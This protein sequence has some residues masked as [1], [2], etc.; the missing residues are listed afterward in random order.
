L[1]NHAAI[2]PVSPL[3]VTED[4]PPSRGASS[5]KVARNGAFYFLSLGVPALTALFLV[6]VTVRSLGP[7]R[8][9]L[10]AL[11]WA[12][13]EGSG[14]F[15]FGLGRATVRF[16]ADA[17]HK[18]R[19]RLNEIVLASAFSQTAA[20]IVA[21]LLLFFFAPLLVSR[22]FTISPQA[23]PE[24]TAMFRVLALHLPVLL[25]AAALR[26]ALEGAQRFDVSAA[27]RIPGSIASVAIPA[28]VAYRGHSLVV[29][30]WWLLAVRVLLVMISAVA[31]THTLKLSAWR[32]PARWLVLGEML[33]YSGWVAVSTALGPLL[34][35]FER[36]AVGSIVGVAALGYYTGAA[37]A[38]NRFLLIPVTAFSALLPALAATDATG[39]RERA[40]VVTRSARRQLAALLFPLCLTLFI[41]APALLG[42]W[43]GPAFAA[44]AGTAL[45]ILSIGVFFGGLAHLPLALLYG[46]NRPDLPAKIHIV[47]AAIY[48]PFA[49]LLVRT[50]GITGAAIAWATRC[51]A[52]LILYETVTRRAL[53]RCERDLDE[54]V[55]ATHLSW[56][57]LLLAGAFTG[58]LW[59]RHFSWAG[60]ILTAA[61]G[62]VLYTALGW[63]RVLSPAERRAW[64][65]TV[66][67]TRA[68][69]P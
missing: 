41:F 9:G 23:I 46:S 26:A 17:T 20:G 67:R 28:A 13:A 34:G 30:M 1:T 6:P 10:L 3:E 33:R 40:L 58:A 19:E 64:S 44:S 2:E 65:T 61:I 56:T 21:G 11:G 35:S 68:P 51:A 5:Q 59:L 8:F 53:G 12:V 62:V 18:G 7:A 24:A 16:V 27:L 60:A 14:M 45:R 54:R 4:Q 15:D 31:V 69:E 39:A 50:L 49:F 48:V 63:T 43:I 22:V 32:L 47:E 57:S 36:F 42:F 37:E 66:L 25:A 52:D 55:R 38:A 29:I